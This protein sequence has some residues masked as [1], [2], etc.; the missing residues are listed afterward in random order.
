M[1]RADAN[2]RHLPV[3]LQG[4]VVAAVVVAEDEAH[5][6]LE[7]D[8]QRHRRDRGG[9]RAGRA[10]RPQ[11]QRVAEHAEDA[12]DRERDDDGGPRGHATSGVGDVAAE[13]ADGR[14]RGQGEVREAQDGVD[15]G[16]A[17][18]RHRQDRPGHQPV[19]E[20]LEQLR[21]FSGA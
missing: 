7:R 12:R 3:A 4:Q 18:R 19:D 5:D 15:R 1:Q 2:R 9:D 21:Q 20:E 14:V 16:E 17:D 13:G 8:I 6:V 11:H 10:Q